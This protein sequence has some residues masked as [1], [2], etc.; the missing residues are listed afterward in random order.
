MKG[1]HDKVLYIGKAGNLRRRVSSYYSRAHEAKLEKLLAEIK[2]I[3]YQKTDTAIEAL[4]L[5][6]QSKKVYMFVRKDVLRA[7]PV[8]YKKIMESKNIEVRY[9]TEVA[10]IAGKEKVEAIVLKSGERIVMDGV[11]VAIGHVPLSGVTEK[12]GVALDDHKQIKINR[13]SETNVPGVFA[14]GDVTDTDFKQAITG[15]SE[16]VTAS[17]HAYQYLQKSEFGYYCE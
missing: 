15:A 1:V 5:A 8:N 7:E 6:G 4:I 13:K 10:E 3:D 11:F 12:L 16:A 14:A 17:Y 9:K 2:K